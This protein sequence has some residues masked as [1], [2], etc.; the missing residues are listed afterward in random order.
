MQ[1]PTRPA[2]LA[3]AEGRSTPRPPQLRL[4]VPPRDDEAVEDDRG[5]APRVP[6]QGSGSRLKMSVTTETALF[7]QTLVTSRARSGRKHHSAR[8]QARCPRRSGSV[9]VRVREDEPR[10]AA[11]RLLFAARGSSEGVHVCHQPADWLQL[12][13]LPAGRDA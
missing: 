9:R 6:R 11:G 13:R 8:S 10:P 4:T 5:D 12:L 2:T 7:E 3:A 1:A